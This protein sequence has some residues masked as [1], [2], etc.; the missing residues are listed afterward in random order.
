MADLQLDTAGILRVTSQALIGVRIGVFGSSGSGKSNTVA[1]IVEQ[2]APH[3]YGGTFFDFHDEAYGLQAKLPMLRVGKNPPYRKDARKR[4][5]EVQLELT[6]ATAADFAEQVYLR[7]TAVIVNLA[8]M[9]KDERQEVVLRYCQRLWD[10]AKAYAKPYWVVLEE[11]HNFIP[12]RTTTPELDT[13]KTFAAEGRKFGITPI[14]ASQRTAKVNKD[15]L[16]ECDYLFLHRVNIEL[17]RQ[18]YRGLLPTE[19]NKQKDLFITMQAGEAVVK[20]WENGNARFDHV[21]ICKRDTVH[22]GATPDG[23]NEPLPT[24]Q[25]IDMDTLGIKTTKP[26]P[27]VT[28]PATNAKLADI[29]AKYKRVNTAQTLT[30]ALMASRLF[31]PPPGVITVPADRV[32]PEIP[33]H[34]P[35]LEPASHARITPLM[36]KD[37]I[38]KQERAFNALLRDVVN[39]C[40][41]PFHLA[42]LKYLVEREDVEMTVPEIA[43]FVG[44]AVQT[45]QDHP[46]LYL[47]TSLML[48]KRTRIDGVFHYRSA[49]R[50]TLA[51][52]FPDLPTDDLIQKLLEVSN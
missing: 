2:V 32:L 43:R 50:E 26:Q 8:Y 24:L 49:A 5:P 22:V 36:T 51:E 52:R 45:V 18:S 46:P 20:W 37:G 11:A 16:S 21:Q 4:S 48:L 1:R 6:P 3:M 10:L 44:L 35:R 34:I 47:C 7:S 23:H 31:R 41:Y 19:I 38:T 9:E 12:Q 15:I 33:T 13:M 14:L 30:I 40:K 42:I 25:T 27:A 17:D 29:E 28:A 39:G